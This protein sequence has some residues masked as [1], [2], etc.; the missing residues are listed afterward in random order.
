MVRFPFVLLLLV[1]FSL[2]RAEQLG[3]AVEITP[4]AGW[5]SV[6][7]HQ[8]GGPPLPPVPTLR[9][10]PSDQRNAALLI[11]LFPRKGGTLEIKDRSSLR[12][13]NLAAARP[14]LAT[15]DHP[16]AA[17]EFTVPQ[18]FGLYLSSVDPNLVGKPTPPGEYR[19]ATTASLLLG[20]QWVIHAT[21]FHDEV[22]SPAFR[23]ALQILQSAKILLPSGTTPAIAKIPASKTD[24][25]SRPGLNAHLVLP[26]R[27]FRSANLGIN[28]DPGYFALADESGVMLSGWLD[29]AGR[30]KGMRNFWAAERESLVGKLG[31]PIRDESFKLIRSW[32]AVAYT[33][34]LGELQQ[35]HLR[36]CR[37]V[38]NTWA[39]VHLSTTNTEAGQKE[40]ESVLASLELTTDQQ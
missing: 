35:T 3:D 31:T 4:I 16:P 29:Q 15:P 22:N 11:S 9:L 37:I 23:E 33:L 34:V 18:G 38:G 24:I 10:V 6:D 7:P 2:A 14:F 5:K 40:L 25:I 8:P 19:V 28:E 17:T 13:F 12:Q 27:R 36:A 32:N 26:P 1:T 20:E 39:D 30:F 21:L